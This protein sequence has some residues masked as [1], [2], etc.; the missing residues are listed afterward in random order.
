MKI[1]VNDNKT[2]RDESIKKILN[3]LLQADINKLPPLYTTMLT[4]V[5]INGKTFGELK[6]IVQLPTS[7]QRVV[8]N[9]A[10]NSLS[11]ELL[12]V[13][14]KLKAYDLLQEELLTAKRSIGI[15]EKQ[16]KKE[17]SINPKLKKL[18]SLSIDKTGFSARVL[19]ICSDGDINKVSDLVRYSERKFRGLRNC[20]KTSMEEVEEFLNK[21][22]LSWGMEI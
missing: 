11:N 5:L 17:A 22:S 9:N 14:D 20:G 6:E 8:F 2:I 4:E 15:L 7:R 19:K 3:N 12:S 13:N 16:I 21:N 1:K 18:L 10:V